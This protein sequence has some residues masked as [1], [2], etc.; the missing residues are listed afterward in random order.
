MERIE[1]DTQYIL[2]DYGDEV[3]ILI[4]KTAD[5]KYVVEEY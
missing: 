5:G 4:T 3:V 2:T 1:I